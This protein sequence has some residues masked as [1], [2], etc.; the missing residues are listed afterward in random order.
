[1]ITR[2]NFNSDG[3]KTKPP[4]WAHPAHQSCILGVRRLNSP[5]IKL[6]SNYW[7]RQ[8]LLLWGGKSHEIWAVALG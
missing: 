2:P 1:M 3:P 6:F 7:I 5:V 4:L 8:L